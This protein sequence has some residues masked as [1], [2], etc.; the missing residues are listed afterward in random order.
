MHRSS[1]SPERS[2]HSTIVVARSLLALAF[3]ALI[4]AWIAQLT[5]GSVIGLSQQH[6]FNDT[7]ALALLSIG[8]FLDALW[9]SRGM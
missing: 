1:N 4:G 3:F 8:V 7:L 9:H 2:V 5:G 6:L